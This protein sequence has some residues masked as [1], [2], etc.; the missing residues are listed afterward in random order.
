MWPT[1][2][3]VIIQVQFIPVRAV[4]SSAKIEGGLRGDYMGGQMT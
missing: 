2:S 1:S 4:G 3:T